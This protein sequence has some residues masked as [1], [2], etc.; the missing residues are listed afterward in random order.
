MGN[1]ATSGESAERF[2]SRLLTQDFLLWSPNIQAEAF[3]NWDRIWATRSIARGTPRALPRTTVDLELTFASGGIERTIDELMRSEFLSGLL[4]IKDGVIRVERYAMGLTADRLWQSSS[5]V[6]SLASIL[7]GAALADGTIASI[8][9]VVT[10]YLPELAGTSYDGV[11]IR[12]LLLMAS[13]TDWIEDTNDARSDV[14]EHYIKFIAARRA[15]TI[16]D[17]L[18]TRPRAF[19][20]GAQYYYNTGDSFL[21]GHILSR[22]TGMTVSAYCSEKF[23]K[24]MGCEQDGFF[25]LDSD[26]GMEVMGS[27]SGA[28]LRDYGRWGLFMLADGIIDGKRVVPEGWIAESTRAASP[29][30]TY[31]FD[32]KRGYGSA[33]PNSRFEGYGYLWWIHRNGAFQALGAFGQWIYVSPK[34]RLVV[35]ML[36]AVPRHVYMTPEQLAQHGDTGHSGSR[37]RLDFIGAV[38]TALA[39]PAS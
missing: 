9:Q 35:V 32:G 13:G 7:V 18:M 15:N 26:D 5:M 10:G 21:L 4:I 31:D 12:H 17:Y 37:M 25:M 22:A 27:C 33:G 30:F 3:L 29:R 39:Q 20:P 2:A 23:W 38:A 1:P 24:P 8:D 28:T 36:S 34:D 19:A 16:V 11:T 14:T 6:K